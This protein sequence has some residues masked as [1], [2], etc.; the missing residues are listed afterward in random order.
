[1][2]HLTKQEAYGR[3]MLA[4]ANLIEENYQ[5]ELIWSPSVGQCALSIYLKGDEKNPEFQILADPDFKSGK[6]NLNEFYSCITYTWD[7]ENTAL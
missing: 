5:C 4:L 7:S 6:R 1:M 3:M 2:K